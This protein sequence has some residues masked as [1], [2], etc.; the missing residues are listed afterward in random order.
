MT[1]PNMQTR[2]FRIGHAL[3]LAGMISAVILISAWLTQQFGS[4]IALLAS[5]FAAIA[6][7]HASAAS[8]GQLVKSEAIN[9][10]IITR[11][12]VLAKSTNDII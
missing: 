3:M 9:L 6:E 4:N 12:L 8:L 11:T 10:Q 7:V 1:V 2:M 5:M